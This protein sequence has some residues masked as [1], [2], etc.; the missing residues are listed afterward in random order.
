MA[1]PGP[2][3]TTTAHYLYDGDST[4]G[5][6]LGGSASKLVGFHGATP[7]AQ[8]SAITTISN[9]A[10]G[11]EIATAVNALITVLKNKGFTA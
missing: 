6:L 9:S 7:V 2:A 1:N 4:D 5:I 8:A 3:S 11:T 10:T